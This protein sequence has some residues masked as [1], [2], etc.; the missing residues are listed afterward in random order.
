MKHD[1]IFQRLPGWQIFL[2]SIRSIHQFTLEG[3]NFAIDAVG[4]RGESREKRIGQRDQKEGQ[5]GRHHH[6]GD[7]ND[8]D[9]ETAFSAGPA[10][11]NQGN[12]SVA[13]M[14]TTTGTA[15]FDGVRASAYPEL[16]CPPFFSCGNSNSPAVKTVV[17][18]NNKINMCFFRMGFLLHAVL[19][20]CTQY[21]FKGEKEQETSGVFDD[22][23]I[24]VFQSRL[25]PHVFPEIIHGQQAHQF[26]V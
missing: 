26:A 9:G 7:D 23:F 5:D 17:K 4:G 20:F 18:T 16:F 8:P 15:V 19:S 13:A 6:P 11:Q 25:N 22:K 2:S 24:S 10:G 3:F 1:I 21:S 14:A 12:G